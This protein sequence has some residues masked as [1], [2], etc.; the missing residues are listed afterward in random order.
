MGGCDPGIT[1]GCRRATGLDVGRACT[2]AEPTAICVVRA[3]HGSLQQPAGHRGRRAGRALPKHEWRCDLDAG[4]FREVVHQYDRIQ[5]VSTGRCARRYARVGRAVEPR[6]RGHVDYAAR[7]R[8]SHGPRI[9]ICV[10]PCRRGYG[11]WRLRERRRFDLG[12]VRV[13]QPQYQ[14]HCGGGDPRTCKAH[15]G[16][17]FA[18]VGEQPAS[19]REPRRWSHL[20][21]DQPGDQRHDR[22]QAH[23]GA[24]PP[25]RQREAAPPGYEHRPVPIERQ[26]RNVHAAERRWTAPHHRL[27]ADGFHHRPLRPFLRGE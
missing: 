20:E 14:C 1:G 15:C 9:R 2:A 24:A 6:Q 4:S 27:H 7:H 5:S 19:L 22:R 21:T 8:W 10:D 12:A 17:R 3:R 18:I 16:R 13:G 23:I 11:P 25:D 26:R